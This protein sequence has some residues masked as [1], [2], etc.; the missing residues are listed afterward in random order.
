[1]SEVFEHLDMAGA[2]FRDVNL[3][4]AEFN[5]VNLGDAVIHN[6]NLGGLCIEDANISGLTVFGFRVDLL[7]S[8]EMDRRDPLRE[9]LRMSDRYDPQAVRR[10]LVRLDRLRAAFVRSLRALRPDL[11]SQRPAPHEWS[12]L[13]TVRHLLFAEEL[14][15][16]R[17]ILRDAQPWSGCGL[18]S[19]F[20]IGQPGFEEVGTVPDPTLEE[21]LSAWER[22][23]AFTTRYAAQV[24]ADDLHR[25]TRDLDFG[26]G[27]VG[28]VLQGLAEHDLDHIRQAEATLR[29]LQERRPE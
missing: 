27:S 6:A 24:T 23:H 2:V 19:D 16:H 26:Q 8:A 5:N 28:S 9:K 17:W 25:G 3:Q 20:L 18:L 12:V 1:M 7:I 11:L 14:Y 21:V 29:L 4:C 15:I 13:E 10:V 22:V